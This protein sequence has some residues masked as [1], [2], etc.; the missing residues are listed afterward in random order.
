MARV[1]VVARSAAAFIVRTLNEKV[2]ECLIRNL[3]SR[4]TTFVQRDRS[5][6]RLVL[7]YWLL[8]AVIFFLEFRY[9][10]SDWAGL[11]GFFLTLPLSTFVIGAFALASFAELRGYDIH[12]T[13]YH[14]QFGFIVG[15]F[16]NAFIFYAIHVLRRR[17]KQPKVFEPP[18]PPDIDMQT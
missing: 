16:L 2:I 11:S 13:D 5:W 9:T 3:L 14:A 17:R 6:L 8:M 10:E 18:P 15:A 1:S 7:S 12:V 4:F